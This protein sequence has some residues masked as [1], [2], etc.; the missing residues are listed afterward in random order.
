MGEGV[1]QPCAFGDY[2]YLYDDQ[3]TYPSPSIITWAIAGGDT[4]I[5]DNTKTWPVG[6]DNDSNGYDSITRGSWCSGTGNSVCYNP[7]IPSGTAE[8]PT[9]F[10]GRNWQ[11]CSLP[12][13]GGNHAQMTKL[14][15]Q[16]GI[17]SVFNA[18]GSQ[19]VDVECLDIGSATNCIIHGS[20]NPNPCTTSNLPVSNYAQY[21]MQIGQ[22]Q[23]LTVKNAYIHSVASYGVYGYVT[24]TVS[25]TGVDVAYTGATG[26]NTDDGTEADA[27][28]GSLTFDHGSITFSGCNPQYPA[29]STIPIT[30]CFDQNSGD[31]GDGFGTPNF[32]GFDLFFTNSVFAY[33]TEDCIDPGHVDSGSH[34]LVLK[35]NLFYGCMGASYKWGENF[36]STTIQN[37]MSLGNC[38]RMSVPLSGAPSTYN[39]YLSLFCRAGDALAANQNPGDSLVF[40]NNTVVAYHPTLFSYTCSG[41]RSCASATMVMRNNIFVGYNNPS[42]NYTGGGSPGLFAD[43]PGGSSGCGSSN[44][45]DS[46]MPTTTRDHNLFYGIG[47]GFSCPTGYAAELCSSPQFINQ[48]LGQRGNFV[49][50]ELDNFN[51]TP[52]SESPAIGAGVAVPDTASEGNRGGGSASQNIGAMQ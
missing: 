23:N 25:M 7:A 50:T 31:N 17:Y 26:I 37:N 49:E 13:G 39:H 41:G 20:P 10:L 5:I 51:F 52:S 46:C 47:H 35:N 44:G 43:G 24:G 14:L 42:Q 18:Q 29:T 15:G 3:H 4:V 48:P 32:G 2:R 33:N 30:Y 38:E 22:A 12:S 40:E 19:Y 11:N 36:T 45:K 21:G 16:Y 8:R 1:N 34:T 9:R 28:N 6:W 27:P